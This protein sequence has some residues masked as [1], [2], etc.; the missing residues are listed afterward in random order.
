MTE[1]EGKEEAQ[2]ITRAFPNSERYFPFTRSKGL[3]TA[4][5]L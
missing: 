1:K 5:P 2:I 3:F 4:K